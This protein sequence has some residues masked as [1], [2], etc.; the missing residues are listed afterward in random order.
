ML[1]PDATAV[2]AAWRGGHAGVTLPMSDDCLACGSR[3]PLGLQ[4]AL[5]FDDEGVWARVEPGLPWRT[6]AA[7]HDALAPVLLDEVAWWLGALTMREG[8]ARQLPDRGT[9][10]HMGKE[11]SRMHE[12]GSPAFSHPELKAEE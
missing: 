5:S 4:T 1:G 9:Y 6:G 3:N 2:P 8:Y 11:V 10:W 12:G 7:L